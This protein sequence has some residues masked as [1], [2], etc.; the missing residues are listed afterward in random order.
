MKD[1]AFEKLDEDQDRE[2]SAEE[3]GRADDV[4]SVEEFRGQFKDADSD[5]D[6]RLSYPEFD[7][8]IEKYTNVDDAF[9]VLDK[10]QD[11]SLGP[12]EIQNVPAFR[13]ITIHH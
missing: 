2:I 12:E 3:W 10:N 5:K 4:L 13:F 7:N 8:Y 9:M 11:N 6:W 1:N